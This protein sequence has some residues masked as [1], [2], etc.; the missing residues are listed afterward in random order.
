MARLR[1]PSLSD[2]RRWEWRDYLAYFLSYEAAKAR[3]QGREISVARVLDNEA[4][5]QFCRPIRERL[6]AKFSGEAPRVSIQLPARNDEVELLATLVSYTL[7]DVEDGVAEVIV[8]DNASTDGTREVIEAC[9]AKYA[10]A[11]EPGIGRA[12]RAAY[13]AMAPSAEFVWLTDC[14][15]RAVAPLRR[16]GVHNPRGTILRTNIR[17]LDSRPDVVGLSTGIVYEYVHPAFAL[18]RAIAVL[19]RRA[20]RVHCGSGANQ[21]IRRQALD[22]IG[23]IHSDIPYRNREDHQ[24]MYELARYAKSIKANMLSAA[25]DGALFAPVYHSG[26]RR[27]KMCDVLRCIVHGRWRPAG[28]RDRWGFPVHPLDRIRA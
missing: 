9:G 3:A 23:G 26:R 24:R 6:T 14:D 5:V 20:P 28:P 22:A 16:P 19:L 15:A 1:R 10:F 2:W 18:L 4:F 12:R 11:L 27:A 13:D 21:F 7:L 17:C 25:T 8:A